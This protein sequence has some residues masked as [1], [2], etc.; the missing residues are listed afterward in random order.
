MMQLVLQMDS[1][2]TNSVFSWFKSCELYIIKPT[3]LKK[4]KPFETLLTMPLV[5]QVI[6]ALSFALCS[7]LTVTD[8]IIF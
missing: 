1:N 2:S 5:L 8:T 4:S 7:Y 3:G 6:I